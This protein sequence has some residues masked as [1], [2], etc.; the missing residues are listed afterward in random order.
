MVLIKDYYFLSS[1]LPRL[2]LGQPSSLHFKEYIRLLEE[3][4]NEEDFT[5]VIKLRHLYDIQNLFFLINNRPLISMGNFDKEGLNQALRF[6]E[7]LPEYVFD[8]W[9]EY[10]TD[11]EKKLYFSKLYHNFF[12]YEI[13]TS[14]GFLKDYLEFERSLRLILL[15]LRA[16]EVKK[17]VVQE[18]QFENAHDDLIAHILSQ[19]DASKYEPP[20]EFVKIK[21][22]FE[23]VKENPL[24]LNRKF[25][26]YRFEKIEELYAAQIFSLDRLLAYLVQLMIVEQWQS[27][28]QQKGE[29]LVN[30]MVKELL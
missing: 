17:D 27:Q 23:S 26:E 22:I 13:Q 29:A 9:R 18:L 25:S 1:S 21:E 5:Q 7:G 20:Q 24:D 4:L 11:K 28:N 19:K 14:K 8:F 16:K 15:A 3:N 6:Q 10:D 12:S 30:A 2:E